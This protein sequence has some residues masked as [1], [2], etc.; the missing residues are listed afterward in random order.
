[1]SWKTP[2]GGNWRRRR[3]GREKDERGVFQKGKIPLGRSEFTKSNFGKKAFFES[4]PRS[5]PQLPNEGK[6]NVSGGG[7]G[8]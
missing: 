5:I 2:V 6:K 1:M 4:S 7:E 3:A 8:G